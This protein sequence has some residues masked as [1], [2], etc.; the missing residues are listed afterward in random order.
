MMNVDMDTL[1]RPR[2]Q[3]R[4]VSL[5]PEPHMVT[6]FVPAKE[7]EAALVSLCHWLLA[8]QERAN[9]TQGEL[10]NAAY[11]F[12]MVHGKTIHAMLKPYDP[13]IHPDQWEK[14]Y[15]NG[16]ERYRRLQEAIRHD[17]G[18][19]SAY[20]RGGKYLVEINK[21]IRNGEKP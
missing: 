14:S 9:K 10:S 4:T 1:Y 17:W 19:R 16:Y 3:I 8:W 20:M 15:V 6:N 5:N 2:G 13:V 18:F 21:G 12:M 11:Y 7:K